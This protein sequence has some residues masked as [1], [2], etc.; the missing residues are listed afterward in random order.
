MFLKVPPFYSFSV[1]KS[2]L[3]FN[4]CFSDCSSEVKGVLIKTYMYSMY[5]MLLL[6]HN[7]QKICANLASKKIDVV[8][9]GI[10][11]QKPQTEVGIFINI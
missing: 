10:S 6:Q 1:H 4:K 3:Q 5:T 9:G 11:W 8:L 2:K 7:L